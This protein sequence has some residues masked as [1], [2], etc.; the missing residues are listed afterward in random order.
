LNEADIAVASPQG[1]GGRWTAFIYQRRLLCFG[2]A[3]LTIALALLCGLLLPLA[4][5]QHP[6]IIRDE[7]P[8]ATALGTDGIGALRFAVPVLVAFAGFAAAVWLARG[9]SG[10]SATALVLGGTVLLS[11]TLIPIN[12]VGAQDIYHNIADARTLWIR[13]DNPTVLPP[14]AYPDDRFYPNV[15][16]WQDFPS[17][18]GPVWY[19]VS[20][21]TVP[22]A[23]DDLWSNVIGQKI[24]T[25][26]FL[27]GATAMTMVTAGRIRPGAAIA[28][29]VMVGWNPLMQFETAG[30]AHNDVVMVFFALAALYAVT[31]RWWLAVFPLL[32]LSVAAKY[33]LILLGPI[34][35]VW[36]LRRH[37][38]PRRQIV[39][40]LLLGA[41]TA[42]AVY[43]PFFAGAD[44]LD[45]FRRQSAFNTSSPSA[46]LDALLIQ[47]SGLDEVES[48]KVTKLIV[49]PLYFVSYAVLLWRIRRDAGVVSLVRTSFW[50][51]FLL[52]VIATWW[53]W[54]WYLVFLVPFGALLPGS[55]PALIGA[56]FAGASMLMYVPY[57]W[58][59]WGDWI[60][61][62]AST[63]GVAFLL[64]VLLA[65]VPLL[66]RGQPAEVGALA[67]D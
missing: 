16:A 37:D 41:L 40:S 9:L 33:V 51:V 34:L 29:G 25:A 61:H 42:A 17:V 10:R 22:I 20:A 54:P 44:T 24:I 26:L 6:Q 48:L 1:D 66:R 49:M 57:F 35:L 43:L 60:V 19:G 8:L 27:L 14:N 36:L 5:W 13:G 45:S 63:A 39:Y 65:L 56:V 46:L 50:G 67:G 30:N 11:A 21:L 31:R 23:G 38:V 4:I 7:Q 58:L 15:T 64:P 52:L 47:F 3:W 59:L 12:P 28:A 2:G 55:R 62:H 53:Y 18:Y 32:A